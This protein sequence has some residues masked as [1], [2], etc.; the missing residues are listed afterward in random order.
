MR[1]VSA[2][3]FFSGVTFSCLLR[4]GSNAPEHT[5]SE[6]LALCLRHAHFGLVCFVIFCC[7]LTLKTCEYSVNKVVAFCMLRKV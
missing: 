2:N 1:V 5:T 6:V 3:C 4:K 7:Y